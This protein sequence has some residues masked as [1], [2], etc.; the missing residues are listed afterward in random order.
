[1]EHLKLTTQTDFFFTTL[2][3]LYNGFSL[4]EIENNRLVLDSQYSLQSSNKIFLDYMNKFIN[5]H[6]LCFLYIVTH[7]H[8]HRDK[9]INT[10]VLCLVCYLL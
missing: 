8:A 10:H 5:N 4:I 3:D 1:M 7:I 9:H 6:A 2:I